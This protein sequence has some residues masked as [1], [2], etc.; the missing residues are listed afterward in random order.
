MTYQN[1]IYKNIIDEMY[2]V[3]ANFSK[4]NLNKIE[5]YF[6]IDGIFYKI[7]IQELS[8]R[9]VNELKGDGYL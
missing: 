3:V 4:L 6:K 1:T 2:K 5:H 9:K 7:N 8:K